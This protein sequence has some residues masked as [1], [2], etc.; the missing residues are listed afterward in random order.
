MT[1][2]TPL[3]AERKI[4]KRQI[5]RQAHAIAALARPITIEV[6]GKP[7]KYFAMTAQAHSAVM[8]ALRI[9]SE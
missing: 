9:G 6:D 2:A 4:S 8:R 7:E 3:R 1:K 5:A